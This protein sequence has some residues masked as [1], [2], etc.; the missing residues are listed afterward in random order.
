MPD[1]IFDMHTLFGPVPPRGG[2]TDPGHLQA[3]LKKHSIAGAVTLSTRGL[4]H[5]ASAGN[6]ETVFHCNQIGPTLLPG[7]VLDPRQPQVIQTVAEARVYFLLPRT[8]HWP[9]A[10]APLQDLLQMRAVRT[11][12]WPRPIPLWWEA[13][14]HGDAT[15]IAELMRTVDYPAPYILG[16]VSGDGLVEAVSVARKDANCMVATDGLRGIGEVSLL[17]ESLGAGRVIFGSG[18]P[19]QSLGSVLAL[20]RQAGLSKAD[21]AL[22]LSG[23]AIRLLS[24]KATTA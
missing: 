21:E 8:Q 17:V 2:D 12:T 11:N 4:Y 23:N 16:G 3:L 15:A 10:Y 13:R 1:L 22:I 7:V 6:R 14:Q 20:V 5:S 18:A 24:K 9:I 19:A